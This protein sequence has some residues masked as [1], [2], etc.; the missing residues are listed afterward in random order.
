METPV[1]LLKHNLTFDP[2]DS[3]ARLDIQRAKFQVGSSVRKIGGDYLF[4]GLVVSVFVKTSGKLRYV[5][6]NGHGIL[7]IFSESNLE[8]IFDPSLTAKQLTEPA[9]QPEIPPSFG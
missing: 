4:E 2:S 6:E 3:V 1:S 9:A 8:S 7:H 5:V